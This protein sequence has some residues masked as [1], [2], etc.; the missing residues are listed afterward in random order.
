MSHGTSQHRARAIPPSEAWRIG[1]H[2]PLLWF[3]D[4]DADILMV[5]ANVYTGCKLAVNTLRVATRVELKALHARLGNTMIYVTHDQVEAMTMA[6]KI[7]VMNEGIIEQ[8]G[9]PLELYNK[10]ANKF[11]A[12]FIGSPKMNFL[13]FASL[14]ANIK[15]LAPENS[16]T[17]G[18]RPE[19]L[20]IK[21]EN[22]FPLQVK[23]VEQLG[24]DS[25]LYGSTLDNQEISIK[26]NNQTEIR[27]DQNINVGFNLNDAHWF[28]S[29]GKIV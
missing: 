16:S 2:I 11:V 17:F 12:G 29:E 24:S 15:S 23:T 20:A 10:P 27:A 26:L 5:K 1:F 28:D 21:E 13:N 25:F 4:N 8:V 19:H 3:G 22:A 7:V 6:D 14:P 18:I 9:V